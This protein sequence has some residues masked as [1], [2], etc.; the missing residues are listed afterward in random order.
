M[1]VVR[2]QDK[3]VIRSLNKSFCKEGYDEDNAVVGKEVAVTHFG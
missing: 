3:S 2:K 1:D